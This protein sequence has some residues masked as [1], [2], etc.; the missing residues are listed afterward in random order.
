MV[1]RYHESVQILASVLQPEIAL[2]DA[3]HE[4]TLQD[5]DPRVLEY[6]NKQDP[7]NP[8]VVQERRGVLHLVH[9]WQQQGQREKVCGCHLYQGSSTI[10][11]LPKGIFISREFTRSGIAAQAA[12][13]FFKS[14]SLMGK[15]LGVVFKRLFPAIHGVYTKAFA[16]GVWEEAD[17]GPFL[18][19]AIVYKLQVGLHQDSNE[20][21]PFVSFPCGKYT[22]GNMLIPQLKIKLA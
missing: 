16:E 10:Y 8:T 17:P 18:G 20:E 13:T 7:M 15:Y 21:G 2:Q 5:H 11:L 12:R 3:R 19:H 9:G 6:R 1:L 14:T 4:L 22:G